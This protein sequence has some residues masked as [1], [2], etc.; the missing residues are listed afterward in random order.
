M[1][2]ATIQ[3]HRTRPAQLTQPEEQPHVVVEAFEVSERLGRMDGVVVSAPDER[4]GSCTTPLGPYARR[5]LIARAPPELA[6]ARCESSK[7]TASSVLLSVAMS[8]RSGSAWQCVGERKKELL[9]VN[10]EELEE[11]LAEE[12]QDDDDLG[13]TPPRVCRGSSGR[14]RRRCKRATCRALDVRR[15]C[16]ASGAMDRT[17]A[18]ACKQSASRILRALSGLGWSQSS[19]KQGLGGVKRGTAV[20][21]IRRQREQEFAGSRTQ[22]PWG[23]GEGLVGMGR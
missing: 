3:L 21:S 12:G 9:L 15:G 2:P 7:P 23:G 6:M 13:K 19:G 4:V 17:R 22:A 1:V 16:A 14:R 20:P 18:F 11:D 8:S 5:L 10:R